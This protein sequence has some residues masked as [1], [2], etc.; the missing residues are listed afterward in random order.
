MKNVIASRSS[1]VAALLP[2]LVAARTHR[3]R[4][5]NTATDFTRTWRRSRCR[6]R[7]DVDE[8]GFYSGF[9]WKFRPATRGSSSSKH[10][11]FAANLLTLLLL[12]LLLVVVEEEMDEAIFSSFSLSFL[13]NAHVHSDGR[14]LRWPGVWTC[15]PVRARTACF[16]ATRSLQASKN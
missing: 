9:N 16:I 8:K 2:F 3:R 12:L 15:F 4:S 1:V 5:D 10:I 14:R 7:N 13:Y 11:S 6:C